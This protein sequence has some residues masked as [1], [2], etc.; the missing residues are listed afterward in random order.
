MKKKQIKQESDHSFLAPH[1]FIS[2]SG[3]HQ[4]GH[5]ENKQQITVKEEEEEEELT[6]PN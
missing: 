6:L 3:F 1:T 2:L 5:Q 4:F